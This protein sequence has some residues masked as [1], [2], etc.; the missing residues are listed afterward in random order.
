MPK[1]PQN[2]SVNGYIIGIFTPQY[3]HLPKVFIK[4]MMGKYSN[5]FKLLLQDAQ[6]GGNGLFFLLFFKVLFSHLSD[7]CKVLPRGIRCIN[8]V[9][10]LPNNIPKKNDTKYN[11]INK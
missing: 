6:C 4:P 2:S 7:P 3:L 1:N 11:I 5:G 8:D 9:A 10:K